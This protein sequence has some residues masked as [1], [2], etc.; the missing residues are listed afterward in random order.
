L[1]RRPGS[2]ALLRPAGSA[3]LVSLGIVAL[4]GAALANTTPQAVPFTQSWDSNDLITTNDDWA[5]VLGIMGYRGDELVSGTGVDP[6]TVVAPGTF[7]EDVNA[8]QTNPNTFTTG[9]VTE[10]H[11]GGN[12]PATMVALT[13]SGTA[14]APHL[15]LHIDATGVGAVRVEY[16]LVDLESGADNA[17]QPV[18]LQYRAGDTGDFTN[19]AEGFEDDAT[20]GPDIGGRVTHISAIVPGNSAD[21]QIRIITTNAVGNDEWVGVDQI[22]VTSASIPPSAVGGSTPSVQAKGADVLLTADVTPGQLPDST[23]LGVDCDASAIGGGA[24]VLNDDGADGDL[25]AGDG[26]F[27]RTVTISMGT[28]AGVKTLPCSVGDAEDRESDFDITLTVL[29]TC[30]DGTVETTETCD[31]GE[32]EPSDGDGC[33]S[34]CQEETGWDCSGEPSVCVDEDECQT[35][36]NEC[37]EHAGCTN[38]EPGYSCDCDDGW[39]GDGFEC[40]DID[41]CDTGA[42]NCHANAICTNND[43]GF[44]CA[45]APG[46][47]GDGVNECADIDECELDTDE[48]SEFAACDNTDGGYTCTCDEGYQGDGATCDPICGDDLVVTGE[49]CDDGG[50]ESGDG[51]SATCE[52]ENGWDCAGA[53]SEC[54]EI[55]QDG[56]VV[57]GEECDDENDV[58]GDG[59]DA[60]CTVEE[61][62]MCTGEPSTCSEAAFCSDGTVDAGEQCDDGNEV[63]FDGC[64]TTCT[65][66]EGYHCEG[67]PSVCLEDVDGDGIEDG[68]DNCPTQANPSQAD[69]DDDGVGDLCEDAPLPEEESGCCSTS[70]RPTSLGGLLLIALVTA[71]SL[72]RRRRRA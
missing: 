57:G 66:E 2:L 35:G 53:P 29:P 4:P 11:A 20:D 13:G 1:S 37:D 69:E 44:S 40:T 55:C 17:I 49:G 6:Q 9:G 3:V 54:T 60:T 65:I 27:S 31:D 34:T 25:E 36:N 26:I 47:E 7:V 41:E 46:Y 8:N 22:S 23:G 28:T 16:D 18:A 5:G 10:F 24:T 58:D 48:C 64:D 61:G 38:Q 15:I 19:V 45:C 52:V 62:W 51:C 72:R 56:I 71:M 14:D 67:E 63:D 30:G 39:T 32:A 59:C 43:G 21:L 68:A 50:E 33:D 12:V 70:S 42:D